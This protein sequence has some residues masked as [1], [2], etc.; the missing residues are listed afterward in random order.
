MALI[1]CPKCGKEI[2]EDA[3]FCY[4]CG[5]ELTLYENKPYNN[6]ANTTNNVSYKSETKQESSSAEE[7]SVA[8]IIKVV[9]MI[10]LV[11]SVIGSFVIWKEAG[12]PLGIA[13][14][15]VSVLTSLLA[16]GVGEIISVLHEIS[17][18][19]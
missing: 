9:S 11:L 14:L 7:S 10:I 4:Y 2:E 12:A 15:L 6:T 1:K 13:S 18:K 17:S 3:E 19:L 8:G 16:Y 5:E